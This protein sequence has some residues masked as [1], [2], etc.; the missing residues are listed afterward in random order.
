MF[1]RV[2]YKNYEGAFYLNIF[3]V[4]SS[5]KGVGKG[6]GRMGCP[7]ISHPKQKRNTLFN[8]KTFGCFASVLEPSP[9]NTSLVWLLRIGKTALLVCWMG[10]FPFNEATAKPFHPQNNFFRSNYKK[11]LRSTMRACLG[12]D[13]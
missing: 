9:P 5:L 6:R 2:A 3:G 11:R 12:E 10:A 8:F 7:S 4:F 13:G 1:S